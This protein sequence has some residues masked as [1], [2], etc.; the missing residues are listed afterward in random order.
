[1][2]GVA[3]AAGVSAVTPYNLFGSKAGLLAALYG[4]M[5]RASEARLPPAAAVDPLS[6]FFSA[7]DAFRNDLADHPA[8][9]RALFAARLESR[10]GRSH[11][12]SFDEGVDYWRRLIG[13]VI[14]AGQIE[15]GPSARLLPRHF[16][17]LLGGAMQEW[18]DGMVDAD[19]WHMLVTHGFTLLARSLA[20]PGALPA[21]PNPPEA[22]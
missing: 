11:A 14:E 13:S 16:I 20:A 1:M 4:D 17:H 2:R 5:V 10:G 12:G 22:R 6:R 8:F 3:E 9:Y 19:E 18:I 15:D 21:R 7:I